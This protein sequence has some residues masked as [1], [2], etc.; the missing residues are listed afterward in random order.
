VINIKACAT[1]ENPQKTDLV[2]EDEFYKFP[3]TAESYLDNTTF[4]DYK[5]HN[6]S[7]D[8]EDYLLDHFARLHSISITA[9]QAASAEGRKEV[10]EMLMANGADVNVK[11]GEYGTALQAASAEGHKEVVELLLGKGADVNAEGGRD[12]T[13]LQAASAR[14]HKEVVEILMANGA[15]VN[16]SKEDDGDVTTKKEAVSDFFYKPFEEDWEFSSR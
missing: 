7:A 12:G 13:A 5:S 6:D 1:D 2:I 10:V 9:L 3:D 14:G 15:D 11:G 4:N 16:A 8:K